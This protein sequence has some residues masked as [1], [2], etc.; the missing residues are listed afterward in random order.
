MKE[1]RDLRVQK[2]YDALIQAFETLLTEKQFEDITVLE[3][4]QTARIRPATFYRH[5]HDKYD[6]F[7]FMVREIQSSHFHTDPE[8]YKKEE[9]IAFYMDLVQQGLD[10][11]ENNESF[12]KAV[13]AN[14]ML[15]F[16]LRGAFDEVSLNIQSRLEMDQKNGAI[17]LC[18]PR[19]LTQFFV[20]AVSQS[21]RWWF[22]HHDQMSKEELENE[23]F[24]VIRKCVFWP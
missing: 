24:A 3:L 2:T 23:L 4:C 8:P 15:T 20:G 19:L 16:I 1:K 9:S 18:D 11:S 7:A 14:A 12:L 10:F 17:L 6:F 22:D 5:F 21:I 13:D